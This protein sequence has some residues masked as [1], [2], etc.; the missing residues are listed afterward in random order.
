[1]A[2]SLLV[3]VGTWRLDDK[4]GMPLDEIHYTGEVPLC[5][6]LRSTNLYLFRALCPV[7]SYRI[8]CLPSSH[9]P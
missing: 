4:I 8:H 2:D 3:F 1:M 5:K 6:L 9:L 7:T